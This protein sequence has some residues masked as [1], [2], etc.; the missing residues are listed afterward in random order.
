MNKII[1]LASDH[2][3]FEL[4]QFVKE[5]LISSGWKCHDFGTHNQDSCDYADYAHPLAAAIENGDFEFG[6]AICGSG[7]GINMTL[8]KHQKIRAALC[9]NSKLAQLAREHNNANI[10]VLP[11]RFIEI[12]DAKSIVNKFLNGEFEGERH[13]KRIAKIPIL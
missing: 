9:W 7:N 10:L 1:G 5:Y 8:N 2:A 12:A 3:G 4:K 6:I 13:T 11:A